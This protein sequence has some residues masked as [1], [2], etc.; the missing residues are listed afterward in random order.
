VGQKPTVALGHFPSVANI[1]EEVEAMR[2]HPEPGGEVDS[3]VEQQ[4]KSTAAKPNL[5]LP[6]KDMEVS[7]LD[8]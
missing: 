7:G 2:E 4:A 8:N 3:V 6:T 5:A 1:R